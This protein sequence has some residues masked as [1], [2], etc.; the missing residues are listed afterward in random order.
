MNA[1]LHQVKL[2]DWISIGAR[3]AV[4][5]RIYEDSTDRIEIV[6]LDDRDRSIYEDAFFTNGKW[7]FAA[8]GHNGGYAENIPRLSEYVRKLKAARWW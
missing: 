5:S 8:T 4:V 7:H 2:K 1:N 6:Y 3:E